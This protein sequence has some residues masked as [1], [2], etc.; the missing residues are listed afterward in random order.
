MKNH[1]QPREEARGGSGWTSGGAGDRLVS[2]LDGVGGKS[3]YVAGVV[4]S[5]LPKGRVAGMPFGSDSATDGH[6]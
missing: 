1:S 6:G 2:R 4:G 5:R 3:Q